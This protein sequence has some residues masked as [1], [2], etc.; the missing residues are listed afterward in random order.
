MSDAPALLAAAPALD[1]QLQALRAQGAAR[2]DPL[3][4]GFIEA[5]ARRLPAQRGQARA[6]VEQRLQLALGE[7]QQRWPA[8]CAT[9]PAPGAAAPAISAARLALQALSAPSQQAA[10]L[11]E[12][13][14]LPPGARTV[15]DAAAAPTELKALRYFRR[16]WSRLSVTQRLQQ[17][18]AQLPA[19]AGPLNSQALALQA[20]TLMHEVS[21][22]YL[23]HFMAY[24][25][26]LFWLDQAP[27]GSVAAP[28]AP[29]RAPRSKT[30]G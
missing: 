1:D 30:R 24:V 20:L 28:A 7:F 25:D 13:G 2:Q 3:R 29:A 18:Q 19:H 27:V 6:L 4:W 22:D 16:S 8:G 15:A 26:S 5:L 10:G 9:E 12:A 17:S 23:E 11:L 21:P 14:G